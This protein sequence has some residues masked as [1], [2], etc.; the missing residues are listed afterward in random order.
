MIHSVDTYPSPANALTYR[1]AV[2]AEDIRHWHRG[3]VDALPRRF[4][5]VVEAKWMRVFKSA[6]S[7]PHRA[8]N[9]FLD[10]VLDALGGG[11]LILS[12]SEDDLRAFCRAR[13]DE[14][15]RVQC[16]KKI[17]E[18]A[19][20]VM[21][22]VALRYGIAP[23]WG[24]NVTEQGK[25]RRLMCERWWRRQVRVYVGRKVERAAITLGMVHRRAGLY[26]SDETVAQ[27]R[28]QKAR[29]RALLESITA[30][31]GDGDSYTL[32]EL[33]DVGT[34]NPE[35]RRGELMTRL[36]GFDQL[37]VLLG[38]SADFITWTAPSRFHARH[39]VTGRENQKYEGATPRETQAFLSGQ[40]A[41]A[42]AALHRRGIGIYGFRVCEPH[43]D[44][45]PH[46]HMI[47]FSRPDQTETVRAVFRKYAFQ[48][49]G[50]EAGADKHR[51]SVEPIDRRKGGAAGYLAKYIA[52][53]VDGYGVGEDYE[54]VQGQDDAVTSAQRVDAWAS[55]WGV[56]QFQQVGG[57]AVSV[58]R[59]LRRLKAEDV[60]EFPML[61]ALVAAADKGGR[62]DG[63]GDLSGWARYVNLMGGVFAKRKDAP[64][65]C[66]RYGG[67]DEATGEIKFN[68]YGE[69]AAEQVKGLLH[70]GGEIVTRWRVWVFSRGGFAAP[71]W[72]S[73]NNCTGEIGG[74][75]KKHE[76]EGGN[77]SGGSEN[78]HEKS[79]FGDSAQPSEG[80]DSGVGR[81]GGDSGGKVRP[82]R[83]WVE[84]SSYVQRFRL[85]LGFDGKGSVFI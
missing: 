83:A 3:R 65:S 47:I 49:D 73:V 46:W 29:N 61:S 14:C 69:V 26:A 52:K 39:S 66:L 10:G 2:L 54:A 74:N 53:N 27:R 28:M 30:T 6:E 11:K 15:L 17:P 59:E 81:F 48:Y 82:I 77:F 22:N 32:Q 58:W 72:S 67:V 84:C 36:A 16:L 38:H 18:S 51:F 35:I 76:K 23:V 20:E 42:R 4:R 62:V 5:P 60:G 63:Y 45:T 1:G 64:V 80:A 12:A 37:A 79:C 41:K 56:R 71:P 31:N 43:H 85:G 68:A 19:L 75:E 50:D 24:V 7:E 70:W 21:L 78:V 40:W 44:G 9:R 57:A 55:R 25:R 13:A 34:S 8:A 33:S